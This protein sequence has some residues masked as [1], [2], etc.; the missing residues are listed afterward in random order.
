[1]Y[2]DGA[3]SNKLTYRTAEITTGT[4]A[5]ADSFVLGTKQEIHST[6]YSSSGSTTTMEYSPDSDAFLIVS[7]NEEELLAFRVARTTTNATSTNV[8]G[9]AKSSV[10]DGASIDVAVSGSVATVASGMTAGQT[11]FF[12][13]TGL[14]GTTDAGFG[15]AGI[16]LSSTTVLMD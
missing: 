16:A 13:G 8:L 6:L 7:N 14:L 3:N 9:I 12:Q 1:M 4:N 5:A 11:Q 15:T 10:S 2:S